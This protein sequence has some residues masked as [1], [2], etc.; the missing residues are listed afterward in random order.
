MKWISVKDRLP[1]PSK[2]FPTDQ[3]WQHKYGP[4]VVVFT[5]EGIIESDCRYYNKFR[6]EDVK[7]SFYYPCDQGWDCCYIPDNKEEKV[8]HWFYLDDIPKPESD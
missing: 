5:Q 1:D 4:R 6:G 8:T 7:S 3:A 2:K